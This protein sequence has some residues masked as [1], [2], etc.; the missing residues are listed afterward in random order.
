MYTTSLD[1]PFSVGTVVKHKSNGRVTT[2]RA[3]ALRIGM[4]NKMVGIIAD[5]I[6]NASTPFADVIRDFSEWEED[7]S[8]ERSRFV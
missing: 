7:S 5:T 8:S 2:I 4:G 3:Y 1:L 6:D